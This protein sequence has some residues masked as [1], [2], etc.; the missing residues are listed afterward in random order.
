MVPRVA[1]IGAGGRARRRM[2]ILAAIDDLAYDGYVSFEFG[3]EGDPD[4]AMRSSVTLPREAVA[5]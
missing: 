1:F 2:D 5:E 3:A 4:E